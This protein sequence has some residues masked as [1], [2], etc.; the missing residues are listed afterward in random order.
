MKIGTV[1]NSNKSWHSAYE[2][3]WTCYQSIIELQRDSVYVN[4][5]YSHKAT[6]VEMKDGR[7]YYYNKKWD[8]V[9]TKSRDAL[10]NFWDEYYYFT[11]E[12]EALEDFKKKKIDI[13]KRLEDDIDKI[14]NL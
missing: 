11:T 8:K 9:T 4:V 2:Y 1:R 5:L 10:K 13:V 14:K 7:V 3:E 12:E 6:K